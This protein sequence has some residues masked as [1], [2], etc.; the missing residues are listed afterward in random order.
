MFILKYLAFLLSGCRAFCDCCSAEI[1]PLRPCTLWH[2]P[3]IHTSAH[4][5]VLCLGFRAHSYSTDCAAGGARAT[6]RTSVRAARPALRARHR[7]R[8]RWQHGAR[9]PSA[10]AATV[11]HRAASQTSDV[12][13]HNSVHSCSLLLAHGEA[14]ADM[15][16]YRSVLTQTDFEVDFSFAA[17]AATESVSVREH[18]RTHSLTSCTVGCALSKPVSRPIQ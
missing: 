18:S 7:R 12:C 15:G 5:S 9:E 13:T 14:R 16:I 8:N 10:T 17:P 4:C 2:G 3:Y 6:A 1:Q 11:R